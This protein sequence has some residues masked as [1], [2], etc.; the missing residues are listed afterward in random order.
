[1]CGVYS[2][3]SRLIQA[4][5][6]IKCVTSINVKPILVKPILFLTWKI[7][8]SLLCFHLILKSYKTQI[9]FKRTFW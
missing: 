4:M 1:M 3:L 8:A 9:E 2:N 6:L 7:N 5:Y